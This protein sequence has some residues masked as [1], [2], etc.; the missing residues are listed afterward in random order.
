MRK[1]LTSLTDIVQ[2]FTFVIVSALA[3]ADLLQLIGPGFLGI[4]WSS[5]VTK[6]ILLVVGMIGT[7]QVIERRLHLLEI[8]D[9]VKDVDQ[10]VNTLQIKAQ[11]TAIFIPSRAETFKAFRDALRQLPVGTKILR[12]QFEKLRRAPNASEIQEEI[13][14]MKLWDRRVGQK[15][16]AVEQIVQI[17]SQR[18]L[19]RVQEQVTK[20]Q[21]VSNFMMHVMVAPPV[22]PY[23]DL[24]V[25]GDAC[26]FL[27]F[28]VNVTSSRET[29][30]CFYI[31]D[32]SMVSFLSQYFN[33]WW[34]RYSVPVKTRDSINEEFIESLRQKLPIQD[35]DERIAQ[36]FNL[37]MQLS[38]D[39][40]LEHAAKQL[41]ADYGAVSVL[42]EE[43]FLDKARDFITQSLEELHKLT[44][45]F[46]IMDSEDVLE[47]LNII[48]KAKHVLNGTSFFSNEAFWTSNTG[49]NFQFAHKEVIQ[50]G[51]AFNRIFI[52]SPE[53]KQSQAMLEVMHQQRE[54]G[55]NVFVVGM[56]EINPNL[57]QDLLIQDNKLVYRNEM[58]P[59]RSLMSRILID[60]HEVSKAQRTFELIML[61]ARRFG[62]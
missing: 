59:D 38:C 61:R 36:A 40:W 49:K 17:G 46:T 44:K 60:P 13:E 16:F 2:I 4:D 27:D 22:T 45:G 39:F 34:S 24:T 35:D 52:L 58:R 53:E 7:A 29:D 57:C 19:D 3:L 23:F 47:M 1:V 62:K 9:R 6:I 12:T 10:K 33:I 41:I 50:R 43:V 30:A 15:D 21:N 31:T 32:P 20:F 18:D 26:A 55:V 56:D 5:Q 25:L 28:S 54:I 48:R 37:A 14:L 8:R 42:Q 51:I 11:P